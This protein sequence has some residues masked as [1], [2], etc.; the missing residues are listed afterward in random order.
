[1]KN[2]VKL[3]A[4]LTIAVFLSACSATNRNRDNTNGRDTI[5][6]DYRGSGADTANRT[7]DNSGTRDTTRTTP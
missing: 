7:I 6:D 5:S 3:M 1:M 4:C 2:Y